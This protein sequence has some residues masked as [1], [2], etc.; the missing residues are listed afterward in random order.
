MA[1]SRF[2]L[3]FCVLAL[4]VSSFAMATGFTRAPAGGLRVVPAAPEGG[5]PPCGPT[6]ITQSS[7]Q[8]ITPQNS[9][10]C[11]AG[12]IH[13]DNSYWRA[14]TLTDSS[15]T[16][17]FAVCA[18]SIGVEVA[19][20]GAMQGGVQPITIRI[21]TSDARSRAAPLPR[22]ASPTRPSPTSPGPWRSSP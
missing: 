16:G 9:V 3:A 17:A 8:T 2:V 11:N 14:F 19:T 21:Y 7:S 4:A 5:L 1:R 12:G 22:S 15:I 20:A 13:T 18:V 10:S 6:T